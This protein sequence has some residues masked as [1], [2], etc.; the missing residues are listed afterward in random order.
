MKKPLIIAFAIASLSAISLFSLTGCW[1]AVGAG[2]GGGTVAYL[3]GSMGAHLDHPFESVFDASLKAMEDLKYT[4]TSQTADAR[5]AEIIAR[6]AK[7][8]KIKIE[9]EYVSEKSSKVEIRV[10]VFGDQELSMQI[11]DQIKKNLQ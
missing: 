5:N 6:N 9:I 1:A 3:D 4:T 10:G 7:D 2:A 11:L 8:D